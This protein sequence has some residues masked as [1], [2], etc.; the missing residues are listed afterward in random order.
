[1]SLG[2]CGVQPVAVSSLES[3]WLTLLVVNGIL[4]QT[5]VAFPDLSIFCSLFCYFFFLSR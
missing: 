3:S 1:M 5:F 2:P 4:D